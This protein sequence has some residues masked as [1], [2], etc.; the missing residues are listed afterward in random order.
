M[1]ALKPEQIEI[2]VEEVSMEKFLHGILPSILPEG[3]AIGSNCFVRPHS[4]KSD[5][6]KSVKNKARAFKHYH[7]PVKLV[8]IHDQDAND[9][10]ALKQ[11]IKDVIRAENPDI[12]LLVRIA[13]KELENWYLGD[14][15]AVEKAY[16]ESKAAKLSRK[17]KFRNPDDLNGHDEMKKI[18]SAFGKVSGAAR[19]SKL[20]SPDKNNSPSFNHFVTGLQKFLTPPSP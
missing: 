6:L 12:P 17:A 19:L 4:G 9:C 7:L 8:V 13:C 11:H 3:F 14:L 10:V 5:L 16:P 20:V 2:L 18:C 1:T 15:E